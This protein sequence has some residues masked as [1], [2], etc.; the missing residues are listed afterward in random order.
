M[1]FFTLLFCVCAL[2][3]LGLFWG[4][5]FF[6]HKLINKY[7][8]ELV[9]TGVLYFA[10]LFGGSVLC[11]EGYLPVSL[12]VLSGIGGL[13][14]I[15]ISALSP[16]KTWKY[17]LSALLCYFSVLFFYQ[18][19]GH[20][21]FYSFALTAVWGLLWAVFVFFNRFPL[22][23][24]LVSF[25]WML[26]IVCV[27]PIMSGIPRMIIAES[28][29]LGI[30]VMVY[31]RFKLL[32]KKLILGETTSFLIGFLWSGVWTYFVSQG[33]LFQTITAYGYYLFEGIIL[34]LAFF[35]QKKIITFPS[36]IVSKL[37]S[38]ST[39][40]IFSH[41]LI[42][43]FLSMLTMRMNQSIIPV[44]IFSVLVILLDLYMRLSALENPLPTWREMFRDAKDSVLILTNELKS[45][46]Q[47][48]LKKSP[49]K[50]PVK[51][52]TQKRKSQK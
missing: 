44:L 45:R 36:D 14:T 37:S 40:I 30:S 18:F 1:G 17:G 43:S 28:A 7:P 42:L 39:A 31:S 41:L 38:K 26:G 13:I 9:E 24:S 5:K 21:L 32:Q 2:M 49:S 50:N 15:S 12:L 25:S 10:L 51:K 4:L 47:K 22:T 33:G 8:S 48:V 11:I 23:S 3:T 6:P 29:L 46:K 27:G 35:F 20:S 34:G 16:S 19:W 52:K